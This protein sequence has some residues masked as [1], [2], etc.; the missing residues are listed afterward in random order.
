MV[1]AIM[2][3]QE[4]LYTNTVCFLVSRHSKRLCAIA[5]KYR[6]HQLKRNPTTITYH[7]TKTESGGRSHVTDIPKFPRYT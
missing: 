1:N 4:L 7:I 2:S 3:V 6:T 5:I